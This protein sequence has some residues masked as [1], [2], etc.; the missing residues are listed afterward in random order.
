MLV[1]LDFGR[2]AAMLVRQTVLSRWALSLQALGRHQ[3]GCLRGFVGYVSS[4]T[5]H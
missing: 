4:L 1:F 2:I 3:L 5:S